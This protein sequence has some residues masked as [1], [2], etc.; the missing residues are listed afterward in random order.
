MRMGVEVMRVM[1]GVRGSVEDRGKNGHDQ[2][3]V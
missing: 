3:K 1:P 2:I